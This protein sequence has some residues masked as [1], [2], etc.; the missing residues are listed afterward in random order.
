MMSSPLSW[1]NRA[2]D[3]VFAFDILLQCVLAYQGLDKEW[4]VGV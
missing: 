3:C 4:R 2:V 1:T